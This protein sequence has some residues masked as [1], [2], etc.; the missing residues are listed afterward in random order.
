MSAIFGSSSTTTVST[1]QDIAV[2]VTVDPRIQVDIENVVDLEPIARLAEEFAAVQQD[3]ND[4]LRVLAEG[5]EMQADALELGAGAELA[6]GERVA[7]VVE[8]F[9]GKL[10]ALGLLIGGGFLLRSFV[11]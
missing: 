6:A 9:G 7:G 8:A 3:N 11:K 2:E 10:A 5:V 4:A 1:A